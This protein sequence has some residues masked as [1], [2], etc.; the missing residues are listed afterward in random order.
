MRLFVAVEL[1]AE[2][3][4][5][6]RA[7]IDELR[8]EIRGARWVRPEGIH[9]T[10]RFLGETQESSLPSLSRE[11]KRAALGATAPFEITVGG[12]GVFPER[13]RPRVLW[14]GLDEPGGHLERLHA[15]I[16]EAVAS[17]GVTDSKKESRP[18][19][20]HL[21]L[22]RMTEGGPPRGWVEA[23]ETRQGR[24]VLQPGS[25]GVTSVCMMQSLLRPAGAEY[26]KLE[27]YPL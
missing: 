9:L 20:P 10:L 11:L 24:A 4:D 17:A 12:L 19:R 1:P 21:T 16:A 5:G 15:R 14:V 3:R 2:L 13:G 27:E 6:L 18:F 25:F 8:E 22:A 26:R 7:L 23:I